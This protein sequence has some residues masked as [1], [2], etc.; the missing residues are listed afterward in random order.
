MNRSNSQRYF[1]YSLKRGLAV[2]EAFASAKKHLTLSDVALMTNM[3]LP[4][5]TRYLH[6]LKDLGY[7]NFDE[8]TSKHYLTTKTLSLGFE[9]FM[10]IHIP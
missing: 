10:D 7:L 9:V 3:S 6:T 2:L 8:T 4:T 5:T 1:I